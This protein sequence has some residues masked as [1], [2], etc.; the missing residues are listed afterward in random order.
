MMQD[1][2][3]D[4]LIPWHQVV[5]NDLVVVQG[6]WWRVDALGFVYVDVLHE[7]DENGEWIDPW[8]QEDRMKNRDI[9]LSA[10]VIPE[11][12][13]TDG[14]PINVRLRGI[15]D[16]VCFDHSVYNQSDVVRVRPVGGDPWMGRRKEG[17]F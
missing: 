15:E 2:I 7:Y 17:R 4:I 6:K 8:S 12:G 16:Q 5:N 13:H 10:S 9:E 14:H 11:F 3:Q 1:Q